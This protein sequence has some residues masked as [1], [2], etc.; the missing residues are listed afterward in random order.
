MCRFQRIQIAISDTTNTRHAFRPGQQTDLYRRQTNPFHLREEDEDEQTSEVGSIGEGGQHLSVGLDD[1]H[2]A[3]LNE[4]HLVADRSFGDDLVARL[5]HF[6]LQLRHHV[7]DEVRIGVGE[8]RNRRDQGTTIVIDHILEEETLS[9]SSSSW[10]KKTN[11]SQSFGQFGQDG[12]F[13]KDFALITMLV[14]VGDTMTHRTGQFPPGHVFFHLFELD[15]RG[16]AAMQLIQR[17]IVY[18]LVVQP[19]GRVVT[20]HQSRDV[21]DRHRVTHRSDHCEKKEMKVRERRETHTHGEHGQPHVD[22]GLGRISAVADAQHVREGFEESHRVL[23]SPRGILQAI[24]RDPTVR[25]EVLEHRD[26]ELQAAVPM[27]QEND[28]GDQI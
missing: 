6:E 8:E 9:L 2:H 21:T 23:L 13:V 20:L 28:Q 7:G 1:V 25:G 4:I 12:F 15:G 11:Q 14:V 5:E 17:E 3:F 16:E 24:Q 26:H 27:G 19:A 18:F 10:R 22:V